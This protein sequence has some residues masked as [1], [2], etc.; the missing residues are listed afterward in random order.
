M[1]KLSES[2][3]EWVLHSMFWH[4]IVKKYLLHHSYSK[5]YSWWIWISGYWFWAFWLTLLR[6]GS[7]VN[8]YSLVGDSSDLATRCMVVCLII[9]KGWSSS[10]SFDRSN[11]F[12]CRYMDIAGVLLASVSFPHENKGLLVCSLSF[13]LS[14]PRCICKRWGNIIL[15]NLEISHRGNTVHYLFHGCHHKHPMDGLRLVFPPAPAAIIAV[16][17]CT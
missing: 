2:L 11:G 12:W 13:A 7:V 17:V 5:S 3:S 10:L 8:T 1:D 15:I 6:C 16:G 9:C 14:S 4:E